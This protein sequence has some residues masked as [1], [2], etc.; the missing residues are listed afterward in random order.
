MLLSMSLFQETAHE[1]VWYTLLYGIYSY[2]CVTCV[3]AVRGELNTSEIA[4]VKAGKTIDG[5]K[6]LPHFRHKDTEKGTDACS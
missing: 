2:A 4:L 6:K 5:D 3:R 1:T